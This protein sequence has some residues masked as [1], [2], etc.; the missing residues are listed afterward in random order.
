MLRF[1]RD[2]VGLNVLASSSNSALLGDDKVG[3]IELI[4]QPSLTFAQPGAAGLFHNALVYG[5][6]GALANTIGRLLTHVPQHYSGTGDHLV[7]EAFYFTDPEGNGL[8]LY[9][10]RPRESWQWVNG[11][12]M[13]DTLYIDPSAYITEHASDTTAASHYLGHVHLRVGDITQARHFYIDILGFT[14]T[15]DLGSALFVSVGGYHHHIGLNTWLSAG[16]GPRTPSLGLSDVTITLPHESDINHLAGRLEAARY[17]FTLHHGKIHVN[18]P[19][20]NGLIFTS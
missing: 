14:L 5:T 9:F 6:R 1:Y 4:A 2:E 12:V 15:G 19:W 16:A 11:H 20:N 13:M 7:S 17:P 18:D 8:E 10:D 3:S